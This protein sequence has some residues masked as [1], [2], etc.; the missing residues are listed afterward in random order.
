MPPTNLAELPPKSIELEDQ[1]K[2]A[3]TNIFEVCDS[4]GYRR[5]YSGALEN[6]LA[7]LV[8]LAEEHLRSEP[9]AR[10]TVYAFIEFLERHLE[11]ASSEAA[12]VADGLGI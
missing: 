5:G 7:S 2:S 11:R 12:Y 9:A 6:L 3:L 1:G 8:P 4:D 10:R